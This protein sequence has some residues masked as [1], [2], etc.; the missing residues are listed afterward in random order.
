MTSCA[1]ETKLIAMVTG[2]PSAGS[3][4]VPKPFNFTE[5]PKTNFKEYR[6]SGGIL[7][8][9][10]YTDLLALARPKGGGALFQPGKTPGVTEDL[11]TLKKGLIQM[12]H[13]TGIV[14]NNGFDARKLLY[15]ILRTDK[16]LQARYHG[17]LEK[18]E[19]VFAEVLRMVGDRES[20]ERLVTNYRS[21]NFERR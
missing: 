11:D 1:L 5:V 9:H 16:K 12:V 19:Q 17:R 21:I 18:D 7:N 14:L 4:R 20:R 15:L 13:E 2:Q 10:D 8:N 6:N 3:E